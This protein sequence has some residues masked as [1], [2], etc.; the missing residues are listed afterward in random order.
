M[1]V[2]Q[3][4]IAIVYD[5]DQTLCPNYMQDEVL[6][7]A[8]RHRLGAVLEAL[9]GAGEG[10]GLR[11]RTGL[12]EGDARLPRD[13]PA[14]ER[15]SCASSAPTLNF[16]KGLPEM[17]DE[18]KNGLLAAG[19]RHPRHQGRALH[20]LLRAE[21]ADRRQRLAPL[22]EGDLRLRVRRGLR[23]VASPFRSASSATRRRR[24]SSSASTKACSTCRRT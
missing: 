18:F 16:Y 9:P 10:R 24:S 20:H 23:R 12:H 7:P 19:A 8:F 11:Q 14:D 2:P 1:S 13:G 4:T 3:N 5:Y 21:G 17:F 15:A 6:F 22:C